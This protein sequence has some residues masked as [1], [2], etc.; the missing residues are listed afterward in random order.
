MNVSITLSDELAHR[1]QEDAARQGV[2][3]EELVSRG[4]Q[5]LWPTMPL[6]EAGLLE[7]I[8]DGFPESFWTVYHSLKAKLDTDTI[9]KSEYQEYMAM[10]D[11]VERKHTARLGFIAELAKMRG[12]GFLE[13][14]HALGLDP[15]P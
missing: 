10:V 4:V 5:N 11:Q 7:K 8:N 12:I 15:T 9:L 14:I 13:T 2:A 6:S 3:I 1:V